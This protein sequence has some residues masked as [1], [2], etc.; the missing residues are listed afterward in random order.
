MEA[1]GPANTKTRERTEDAA[2]AVLRA[3]GDSFSACRVDPG[4]KTSTSFGVKAEPPALP[5]RDDVLVEDGA[6]APKSCL[7]SLEM[8]SPTAAGGVVPTG[9]TSKAT[10]TTVNVNEPVFQ[11]YLTEEEKKRLWTSIPSAWYD[12]SFWKLL[13]TPSGRRVVETKSRQNRT[14]DPG[15]SQGHPRACPLLGSWRALVCGEVIRAGAA[16]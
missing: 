7:L 2:T 9:E 1:D 12:S 8:R 14:F 11:F 15:G 3:R 4:P 6:A 10:E 5:C 13:A 16:G